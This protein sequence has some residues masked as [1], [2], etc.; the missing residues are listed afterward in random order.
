MSNSHSNSTPSQSQNPSPSP[1]SESITVQSSPD[2]VRC[3][4]VPGFI[5]DHEKQMLEDYEMSD[6]QEV[7]NQVYF[8]LSATVTLMRRFSENDCDEKD[9]FQMIG[10]HLWFTMHAFGK[11]QSVL[12][13]FELQPEA[14][15]A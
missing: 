15:P 8:S 5:V 14:Q 7:F 10:D 12:T 2:A 3:Y 9:V 13:D 1:A 4:R 6:W 11:L